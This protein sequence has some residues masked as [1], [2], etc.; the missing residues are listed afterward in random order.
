MGARNDHW[1][2]SGWM[3]EGFLWFLF[4]FV[5]DWLLIKAA[6]I[7]AS[8]QRASGSSEFDRHQQVCVSA[9]GSAVVWL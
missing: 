7:K 2:D 3:N 5:F 9:H 1:G 8:T 6:E 4:R